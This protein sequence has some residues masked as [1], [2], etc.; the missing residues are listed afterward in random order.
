MA[1]AFDISAV[2]VGS[3]AKAVCIAI[4]ASLLNNSTIGLG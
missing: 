4:M 2:T 3:V 1:L